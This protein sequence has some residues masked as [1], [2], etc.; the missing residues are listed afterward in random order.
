V[1]IIKGDIFIL[2]SADTPY[3]M[4]FGEEGLESFFEMV[5]KKRLEK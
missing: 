5:E 3:R 4:W 1:K 2:E